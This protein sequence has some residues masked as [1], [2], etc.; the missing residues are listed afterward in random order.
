MCN[1]ADSEAHVRAASIRAARRQ[2]SRPLMIVGH[3]PT[4]ESCMAPCDVDV[5]L[6]VY[7]GQVF[8]R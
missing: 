3:P 8:G 6:P 1:G 5:L 7:G 2:T 4:D